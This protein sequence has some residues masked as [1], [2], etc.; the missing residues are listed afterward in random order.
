MW[1]EV[2]RTSKHLLLPP[3]HPAPP[4]HSM[5]VTKDRKQ[6]ERDLRFQVK[7]FVLLWDLTSHW[8]SK[9]VASFIVAVE[10]KKG[11]ESCHQL[12]RAESR[13]KGW[14]ATQGAVTLFPQQG[15]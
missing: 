14:Q 9:C 2:M 5:A 6:A 10:K 7:L 4:A 11:G 12:W 1:P 3:S 8:M 13:A 15:Y